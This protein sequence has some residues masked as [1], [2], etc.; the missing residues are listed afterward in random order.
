MKILVNSMGYG[1]FIE[2]NLRTGKVKLRFM[3]LTNSLPRKITMRY[4]ENSIIPSL[5]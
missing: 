3:V 4:R 5:R 1:I 2:L